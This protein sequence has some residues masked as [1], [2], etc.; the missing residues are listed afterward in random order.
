MVFLVVVVCNDGGFDLFSVIVSLSRLSSLK[1]ICWW[2]R[3]RSK[4][5]DGGVVSWWWFDLKSSFFIWVFFVWLCLRFV[6]Y[7]GVMVVVS[8]CGGCV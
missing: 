5:S 2:S 8:C 6:V 1:H 7:G 3:D 4:G